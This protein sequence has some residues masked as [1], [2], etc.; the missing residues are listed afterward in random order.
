MRVG[1]L[2]S[3]LILGA[4]LASSAAYQPAVAAAAPSGPRV[5]SESV[6]GLFPSGIRFVVEAES[7]SP[8]QEVRLDYRVSGARAYTYAYVEFEPG[9]HIQGRYTLKSTGPSYLPVGT[10]VEYYYSLMDVSGQIVE[11]Q[12]REFLYL[13]TR[14]QWQTTQV[15]PLLIHWHDLPP[16]QVAEVVD[17][18]ETAIARMGALL[19]VEAARLLR[20]TIYNSQAEAEAAFPTM[21]ETLARE[22]VFAGY[23]FGE[24]GVFL[25]VGMSER[26]VVHETAH[27][28]LALARDGGARRFPSWL[29]E[30]FATYMEQPDLDYSS[31]LAALRGSKL[32]PLQSMNALPGL[33]QEIHLFYRQ[34]PV[35]V[36]YLLDKYGDDRFRAFLDAF[37]V[38]AGADQALLSAY[39]VGVEELDRRWRQ[40]LPDEG[41]GGGLGAAFWIEIVPTIILL[42]A[43]GLAGV[44]FLLRV[45]RNRSRP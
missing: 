15:G 44:L 17:R 33:E 13:D 26:I 43:A 32:L 6:E 20:G 38:T 12:P 30:G 11:T 10:T 42:G 14:F 8:I 40:G 24:E 1:F 9:T 41:G 39:G 36:A 37:G 23:A 18:S 25:G 16:S 4:S 31:R 29:E 22:Q 5:L 34:A 7:E 3:A 2:L 28:Y 21:S 35:V 27:L 45:Y 19:R